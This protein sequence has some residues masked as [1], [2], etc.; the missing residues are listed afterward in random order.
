MFDLSV[1]PL[2]NEQA[3]AVAARGGLLRN[4]LRRQ[5]EM[6]IS[7]SHRSDRN[8]AGRGLTIHSWQKL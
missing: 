5:I 1:F 8:G 3:R 7:G 6:E 4:Q 2:Q